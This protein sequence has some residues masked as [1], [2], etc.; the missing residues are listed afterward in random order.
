MPAWHGEHPG[1]QLTLD[2]LNDSELFVA[3]AEQ[4]LDA[5]FVAAHT[6]RRGANTIL[7]YRERPV[8]A[9]PHGHELASHDF[10]VRD[11]R[12]FREAL[13]LHQEFERR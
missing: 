4:T 5:A 2:E 3:I 9:L 10:C 1:V 12:S 6:V 7:V 11:S 13:G 8:V